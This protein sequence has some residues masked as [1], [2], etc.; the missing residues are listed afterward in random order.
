MFHI[1]FLV[2]KCIE[3]CVDKWDHLV[4][5]EDCTLLHNK[6]EYIKFSYRLLFQRKT[7]TC[8]SSISSSYQNKSHSSASKIKCWR[9]ISSQLLNCAYSHRV[10]IRCDLFQI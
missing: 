3:K 6:Q 10:G 2:F 1:G 9:W 8:I 4:D 5:Q 7:H